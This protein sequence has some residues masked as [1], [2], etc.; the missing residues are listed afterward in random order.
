C[1]IE[2]SELAAL[3]GS[4]HYLS[5]PNAPILLVEINEE[6][7]RAFGFTKD[8]IWNYLSELG[9]DHFYDITSN[10]KLRRAAKMSDFLGQN[11]LC[12]KDKMIEHRLAKTGIVI[13]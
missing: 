4:R 8:D 3:R 12:A 10:Q 7:S 2:G 1:D 13:S 6:T 5:S 9:Y 11:L